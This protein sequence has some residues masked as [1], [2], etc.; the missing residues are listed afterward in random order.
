[1]SVRHVENLDHQIVVMS[2]RFNHGKYVF[3]VQACAQEI[4]CVF[5]P[6]IGGPV[7]D[8]RTHVVLLYDVSDHVF[9]KFGYDGHSVGY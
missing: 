7:R 8:K 2:R 9:R 6:V 5:D 3:G 1:M 4:V